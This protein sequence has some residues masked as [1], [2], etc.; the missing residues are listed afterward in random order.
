MKKQIKIQ[1]SFIALLLL[2]LSCKGQQ[3]T[4][5]KIIEL[6]KIIASDKYPNIDGIVVAKDDKIIIEEYFNGFEKDSLHDTRSSFKSVT[7]LLAGIAIDK[8]LFK[9]ENKIEEF[10]PEW[11]ND[12]RGKITIKNLLEMK[13]GLACEGFFGIGPDCESDMWETEDWLSYILNI[14]LRHNPELNWAYTSMEPELVGIIISRTSGMTLMEFAKTHLFTPLGIENYKWYITPNGGGYAAGSF[15]MKPI[16]M[17]KIAQLVLNK[18]NWGEQ[19]IVSEKWIDESTNCK[20]D[21]EMSFVR[22]AQTQNAKYTTANYGYL[23]YR[24]LLQYNDIKTE[25]LF[26]SGNGGQYMI[27]LEDYNT[28]IAFT[29]S[30]YGNWRGKLPFEIILKYLIPIL[31]EKK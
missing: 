13:S 23:W 3:S 24:E 5:D 2:S 7:S 14:P 10:I 18:G 16:D 20:I 15:N 19:Q 22:F 31:E 28:A 12:P 9:V 27:I 6:K 1:Y 8:G 4:N 26:A 30:N 29:G 21:V 25:A 17:L 11:K